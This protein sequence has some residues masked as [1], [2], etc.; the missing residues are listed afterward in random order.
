ML[1]EYDAAAAVGEVG[2][3]QMGL[4]IMG[5]YTT[6]DDRVHMCY[7]FELLSPT[8]PTAARMVKV[9]GD[10]DRVDRKSTRL[11]SSHVRTSRMP[12]SA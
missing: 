3:A 2:D 5:Q 8:V 7:S 4:E 12:S 11:N 1:E 9:M 6:G 10:V